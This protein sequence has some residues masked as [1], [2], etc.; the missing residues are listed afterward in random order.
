MT[1]QPGPMK[2]CSYTGAG[3]DFIELLCMHLSPTNFSTRK[4]MNEIGQH[5]VNLRVNS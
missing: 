3:I 2:H 4:L 5:V 1:G